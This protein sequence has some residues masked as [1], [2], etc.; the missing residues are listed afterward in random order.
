[1][2]TSMQS[3]PPEYSIARD[4]STWNQD[5]RWRFEKPRVQV[6][7]ATGIPEDRCRKINLGYRDPAS[8]RREEWMGR[9][10]EGVL[11]VPHAGEI[12]HR[13][14]NPPEWARVD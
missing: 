14:K 10:E 1:M 3:A 2:F 13:L 4:A 6:T 5:A 12:L 9:E 8:I 11:Y 7:L